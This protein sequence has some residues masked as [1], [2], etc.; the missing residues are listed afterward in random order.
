MAIDLVVDSFFDKFLASPAGM[1][2]RNSVGRY[3]LLIF[4]L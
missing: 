4:S 3:L 2:E 1:N